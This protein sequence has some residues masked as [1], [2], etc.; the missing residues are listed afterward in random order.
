M[1]KPDPAQSRVRDLVKETT[2]TS[3]RREELES[4]KHQGPLL[5]TA[6]DVYETSWGLDQ[7]LRQ[8]CVANNVTVP[9]FS[10]MYKLYE[11]QVLGKHPTQ[12]SNDKSNTVKAL[13]NGH[14]TFKKF[15]EVAENVLGL[16]IADMMI[17]FVD[18][19]GNKQVMAFRKPE[20]GQS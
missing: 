2:M 1:N 8:L 14:I 19:N 16:K 7:I 10:E 3:F 20:G 5:F 18:K 13:K 11:L 17:G 15:I 4:L 6:E 9:Y 12:A